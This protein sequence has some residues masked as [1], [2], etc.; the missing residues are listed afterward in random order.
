MKRLDCVGAWTGTL[1]NPTKCLWR[2][3]PG[4]RS[5]YFFFSPPVHLC[6]VTCLTETSLTVKIKLYCGHLYTRPCIVSYLGSTTTMTTGECVLDFICMGSTYL[7]GTAQRERKIQNENVCLQRD[8]NPRFAMT[9]LVEQRFRQLGYDTLMKIILINVLM[10]L[11]KIN[12]TITW[13]HG[14]KWLWLHHTCVIELTVRLSLHFLS[15]F[16]F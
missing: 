12:K 6:A 2:W 7:F 10:S 1:K 5:N 14:S 9:R 11:D 8:S 13:Q 4:C 15:Q 16:R 3:E